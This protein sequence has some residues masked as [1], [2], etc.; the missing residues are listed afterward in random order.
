[1]ATVEQLQAQRDELVKLRSGG[2]RSVAHGDKRADFRS[3]DEIN[4]AIR[5]LDA[6]IATLQGRRR[7]R[8]IKT[9]STRGL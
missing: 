6:D 3:L 2:A 9:Y 5:M 8:V 1:M 7:S 4:E